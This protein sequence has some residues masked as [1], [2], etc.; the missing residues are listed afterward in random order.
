MYIIIYENHDLAIARSSSP[1]ADPV[2]R[3]CR[4]NVTMLQFFIFYLNSSLTG[5]LKGSHYKCNF[6]N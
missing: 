6:F 3:V 4:R 2:L 1:R 5:N